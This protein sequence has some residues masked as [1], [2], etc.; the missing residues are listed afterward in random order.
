MDELDIKLDKAKEMVDAVRSSVDDVAYDWDGGRR[1]THIAE[2][3]TA[4][5][6]FLAEDTDYVYEAIDEA[7]DELRRLRGEVEE[8]AKE[9][10]RVR[11]E[12]E[13]LKSA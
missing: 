6:K 7:E 1:Q 11:M 8:L 12:L 2:M 3:L 9:L 5:G 13:V 4:A 10:E